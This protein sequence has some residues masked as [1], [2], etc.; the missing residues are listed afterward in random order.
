[1]SAKFS[2]TSSASFSD[3]SNGT[4][5]ANGEKADP[6]KQLLGQ[7]QQ[8]MN[9]SSAGDAY[10]R[11]QRRVD[12][13]Q[14]KINTFPTRQWAEHINALLRQNG[15]T[16]CCALASVHHLKNDGPRVR[17]PITNLDDA[18]A[19]LLRSS[20]P[21]NI[22]LRRRYTAAELRENTDILPKLQRDDAALNSAYVLIPLDASRYWDESMERYVQNML[23][24][25]PGDC[26]IASCGV[27]LF[28]VAIAWGA[29]LNV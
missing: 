15:H 1:M 11:L 24:W 20:L 2:S 9:W 13:I 7:T 23:A 17:M 19:V 8:L 5:A 16:N 28:F 12:P 22:Q 3:S 6:T 18:G 27:F 4:S 26:F 29:L 25:R 21:A 14:E 10:L